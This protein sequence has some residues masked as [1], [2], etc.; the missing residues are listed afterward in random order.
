MAE[1]VTYYKLPKLPVWRTVSFFIYKYFDNNYSC[2]G[3]WMFDPRQGQRIFL[4]ASAP[5]PALGP[6]QPPIQWVP[7]VLSLGVKHG[8]G[9]MLTNHPH[10][11]S[12]LRMSMSYTS[13]PPHVPPWR[14]AGQI[15]F[16]LLYYYR[17]NTRNVFSAILRNVCV[18]YCN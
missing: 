1:A 17:Y 18:K 8:R 9:V 13:S 3:R 14:V 15:Y 4:L 10:L 16:Y 5:R 7:G 6:T 12:R 11:V 2:I